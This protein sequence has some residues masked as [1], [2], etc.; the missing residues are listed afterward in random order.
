MPFTGDFFSLE[1][2][3]A[4]LAAAAVERCSTLLLFFSFLFLFF[5]YFATKRRERSDEQLRRAY[6]P[7]T[8]L[9]VGEKGKDEIYAAL[10]VKEIHCMID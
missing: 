1:M 5:S 2:I 9:G 10:Y 6:I 7:W 8:G 4:N 3:A